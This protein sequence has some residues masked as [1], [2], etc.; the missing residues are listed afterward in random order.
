M[1]SSEFSKATVVNEST[2]ILA[3]TPDE[4]VQYVDLEQ[5]AEV[6]NEGMA[7][8]ADLTA[9]VQRIDG[10]I[11]E[12]RQEVSDAKITMYLESGGQNLL[13]PYAAK[14]GTTLNIT[15]DA[16]GVLSSDTDNFVPLYADL[17]T[18]QLL[19]RI[20]SGETETVT[21]QQDMTNILMYVRP[22]A[23][24]GAGDM[25]LTISKKGSLKEEV[26]SNSNKLESLTPSFIL[27]SKIRATIGIECNL[28][29]DNVLLGYDNINYDIFTVFSP[30]I[31]GVKVFNRFIRFTPTSIGTHTVT[32]RLQNRKTG[33]NVVNVTMA[34]EIVAPLSASKKV[35]FIGDSLTAAG[36]YPA[37]IQHVLSEGKIESLGTVSRNVLI[38]GTTYSISHEGRSGWA[39]YD[40][41]RTVSNYRTDKDN[42]FWDGSKF[43]F[44]YYMTQQGYEGVDCVFLNLGTNAFGRNEEECNALDIMIESIH[45]YNPTIPIIISLCPPPATQD[46]VG[47][48]AGYQYASLLKRQ[49]LSLIQSYLEKYQD[50]EAN[51][52]V[53]EVYINLDRLLDFDTI[54]IPA[55]SRNPQ[56]ITVQNNNVHPSVYGY[57]K[58]GDVYYSTIN[59]VLG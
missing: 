40:Y 46:G 59:D 8:N 58:M 3:Q 21:L 7:T 55:S 23:F 24:L 54:E 25:T 45:A 35:I 48:F 20:S 6:V 30:A 44:S 1:F 38:E 53:S 32:L 5:I 15:M 10:E 2:R 51:V 43:D 26:V 11:G 16:E 57:L 39:A 41:T 29:Y 4:P 28:Y 42:P 56:L 9:T 19:C 27:P 31:S 13:F 14:A 17:T 36:I 50:K 37:F 52:F 12:L 34:L 49:E 47:E 18:S 22:G 33:E